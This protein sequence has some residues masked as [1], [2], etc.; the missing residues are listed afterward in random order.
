MNRLLNWSVARYPLRH[1]G[2]AK[3]EPESSDQRG[4]AIR[5]DAR[6][7]GNDG[8]SEHITILY[9]QSSIF[10]LLTQANVLWLS[11]IS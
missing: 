3:R 10:K 2:Q 5:L 7:R 6:L 1:S 11:T 4:E 8:C 9:L